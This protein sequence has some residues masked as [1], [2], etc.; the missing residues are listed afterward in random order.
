[1]HPGLRLVPAKHPGHVFSLFVR[2]MRD[3]FAPQDLLPEDV[4]VFSVRL[5]PWSFDARK[6]R[7]NGQ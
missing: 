5:M 6:L 7:C 2:G 1:M 4:V 3:A